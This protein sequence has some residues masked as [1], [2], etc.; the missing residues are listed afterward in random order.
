MNDWRLQ[1]GGPAASSIKAF[2]SDLPKMLLLFAFLLFKGS[3][4]YW[5]YLPVLLR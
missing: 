3:G 5:E 4:M 1:R 2:W